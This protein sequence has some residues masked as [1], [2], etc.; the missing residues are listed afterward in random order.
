MKKLFLTISSLFLL[1]NFSFAQDIKYDIPE[2]YESEISSA[3]YKFL[4]DESIIVIKENFKISSVK[5]GAIFLE[6]GQAYSQVNLHNL[7]IKCKSLDEST[8]KEIIREHFISMFEASK[9]QQEIDP[10]NFDQMKDYLAIRIY[11]NSFV[12]YAGGADKLV[13]REDLKGTLSLV[14]LDLPTAFTPI[15]NELL[16][17]WKKDKQE[18]FE[19][20]QSNV[21]KQEMAKE[22][23]EL[24]LNGNKIN[25]HLIEN[26]NYGA[27]LALD[28]QKNAPELVGDWGAAVA[29]PNKGIINVCKI[30]KD[31]PLD[32]ILF[33]QNFKPLVEQFYN[34]HPQ[35]ISKDFYWYYEGSYTKIEVIDDGKNINVVAP[36]ALGELMSEK[37]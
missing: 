23:F 16:E 27:S 32:F 20:A 19:I 10:N 1:F 2:G 26:E 14:V 11:E 24:E 18:I 17:I 7:I 31:K 30:S 21:N 4:V 13:S 35:K 34:E 12:E 29:I 15:Q 28:L 22:T 37:K 6:E 25:I 3:D 5:D 36:L 8:R 33:I 9:M